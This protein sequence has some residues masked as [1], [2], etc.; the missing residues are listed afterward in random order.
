MSMCIRIAV[1]C[2]CAQPLTD[3]FANRITS[4]MRCSDSATVRSRSGSFCS[5]RTG[6]KTVSVLACSLT[7]H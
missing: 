7:G 4:A 5:A 3:A 1:L 2:T 6:F